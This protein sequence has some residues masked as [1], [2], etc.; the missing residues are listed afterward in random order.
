MPLHPIFKSIAVI[1]YCFIILNGW[2]IGIPFFLFLIFSLVE[3]GTLAQLTALF[4][5]VGFF[6]L[7]FPSDF[8]TIKRAIGL[9]FVIYILLLSPIVER[10]ISVSLELFNYSTFITPVLIF[11][12]GFP[13]YIL[14]F[15][16]YLK[17][18]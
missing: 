2:M 18:Q 1:A 4:S 11:A 3:F 5:L 17:K 10:L 6:L 13:V 15:F 14:F 12:I 9:Q 7:L 8:K 16:K